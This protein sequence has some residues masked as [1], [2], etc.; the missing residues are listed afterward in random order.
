MTLTIMA[1]VIDWWGSY[2]GDHQLVSVAIRFLHLAGLV[3]GGGTA[4]YADRQLL[5]AGRRE[6]EQQET[7]LA[8]LH[9]SH[10]YVVSWIFA[11]AIT[12][13]AMTAADT[14][15]FLVSEVYWIKMALVGLLMANG[16][17]LLY[18]ERRTA[19]IGTAAAWPSLV[20]A[21]SASA[22]LWL[23]TLFMGTLLT[24]AA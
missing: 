23:A 22:V 15:T 10:K 3:L 5:R 21:A 16:A 1:G 7:V 12:G 18:L 11:V 4:L 19:R 9:R 8:M 20:A 6:P 14:Q 2:Y 13:A 17:A 24:V